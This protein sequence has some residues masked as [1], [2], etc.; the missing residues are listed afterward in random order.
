MHRDLVTVSVL[1]FGT[2]V[3]GLIIAKSALMYLVRQFNLLCT[4]LG[5]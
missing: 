3:L 4:S 1:G 2:F 5:T